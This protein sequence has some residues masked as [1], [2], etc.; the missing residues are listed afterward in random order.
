MLH[1][2][3]RMLFRFPSTNRIPPSLVVCISN[4]PFSVVHLNRDL[5]RDCRLLWSM[6]LTSPTAVYC[7]CCKTP[8][9]HTHAC[10]FVTSC[11]SPNRPPCRY[12]VRP[13]LHSHRH[14]GSRGFQSTCTRV[15][16]ASLILA[17]LVQSLFCHL[18]HDLPGVHRQIRIV[19]GPIE[20]LLCFWL[21]GWV[22]V[23]CKVWVCE[24]LA[25]LDTFS[26]IEDQHALQ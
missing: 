10:I 9:R 7:F 4:F 6:K 13:A 22:M 23:R 21:I 20:F 12:F 14:C 3:P 11:I 16:L 1:S 24:R 26:G 18:H 5:G 19:E 15:S 25:G 17:V 2:M 8:V